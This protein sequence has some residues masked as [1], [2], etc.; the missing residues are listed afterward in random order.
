M[1]VLQFDPEHGIGKGFSNYPLYF[2]G[3]FFGH[4]YSLH[5]GFPYFNPG[6][7]PFEQV[8]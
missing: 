3:F 4:D 8:K 5:L 7:A 6:L 2:Y 1:A